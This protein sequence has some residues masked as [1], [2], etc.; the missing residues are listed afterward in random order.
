MLSNDRSTD[1]KTQPRASSGPLGGV[2]RLKN[3]TEDCGFD[4]RAIILDRDAYSLLLPRY[5]NLNAARF[6]NF[7]NRLLGIAHQIEEYLDKLVGV[8]RHAWQISLW[9][10]VY[11]YGIT[12]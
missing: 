1:T 8:A 5:A 10:E 4:S 12:A 6:A 9:L 11:R 3:S 2:E 7:T